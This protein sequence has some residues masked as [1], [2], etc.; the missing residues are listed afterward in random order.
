MFVSHIEMQIEIKKER[1]QQNAFNSP[2]FYFSIELNTPKTATGGKRRKE[3]AY[4]SLITLNETFVQTL[5]T[6]SITTA[7]REKKTCI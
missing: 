4:Y 6:F 1:K 7:K 3:M 5:Q 2:G